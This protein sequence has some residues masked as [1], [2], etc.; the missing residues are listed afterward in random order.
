MDAD[1]GKD[2]DPSLSKV[3][4]VFPE[5]DPPSKLP[6]CSL[7]EPNH[8]CFGGRIICLSDIPHLQ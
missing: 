5:S 3:P 8:S 4:K 1:P 2:T 6:G 7:G